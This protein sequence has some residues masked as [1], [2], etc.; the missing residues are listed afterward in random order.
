[1]YVCMH[2]YVCASEHICVQ[3]SEILNQ[4]QHFIKDLVSIKKYC[5]QYLYSCLVVSKNL[6]RGNELF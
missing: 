4:Y 1:M 2:I 6:T 5:M 3:E